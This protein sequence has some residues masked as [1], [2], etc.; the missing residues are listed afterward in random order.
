[1]L[2]GTVYHL[3]LVLDVLVENGAAF[4]EVRLI[5]GGAKSGLLRKIM[6]DIWGVPVVPMCYL[7]EASSLGAALAGLVGVGA[8]PCMHEAVSLVK[9]GNPVM[10]DP[11]AHERYQRYYPLFGEAY[12]ALREVNAKIHAAQNG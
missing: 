9:K 6:A 12:R 7:E 5:G 1:V 3:K 11:A 4:Q 8:F 2:E 10:P